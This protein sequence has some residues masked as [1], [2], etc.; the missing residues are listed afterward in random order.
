MQVAATSLITDDPAYPV[1]LRSDGREDLCLVRPALLAAMLRDAV[2]ASSCQATADRAARDNHRLSSELLSK[3]ETLGSLEAEVVRLNAE[4]RCLR[5]ESQLRR[6]RMVF[7]EL[8]LLLRRWVV[9]EVSD[10]ASEH[11]QHF[12]KRVLNGRERQKWHELCA[13]VVSKHARTLCQPSALRSLL[14]AFTVPRSDV[15]APQRYWV[16]APREVYEHMLQDI[17]N[18][19][20][21][22]CVSWEG[23]LALLSIVTDS[24]ALGPAPFAA[25]R[26]LQCAASSS[27]ED[28]D[29]A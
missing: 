11:F 20:H 6:S 10:N 5:Y 28:S 14:N 12:S 25:W 22:S 8:A 29:S 1:V 2:K 16:D 9:Y 27:T 21:D 7:S 15:D 4:V 18:Y 13:G 3:D 24:D 23:G 26:S 19:S 17:V